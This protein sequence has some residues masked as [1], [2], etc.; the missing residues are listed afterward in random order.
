[1]QRPLL[2]LAI[3]VVAKSVVK[4][5]LELAALRKGELTQRSQHLARSLRR[6]FHANNGGGHGSV[7]HD[8]N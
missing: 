4:H 2:L 6:E 1:M 5:G 7:R 3:N 8:G